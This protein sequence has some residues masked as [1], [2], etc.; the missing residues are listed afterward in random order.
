M[1]TLTSANFCI[2]FSRY[3]N[4]LVLAANTAQSFTV[5]AGCSRVH[6][7]MDP[8]GQT[9]WVDDQKT[10][11]IPSSNVVDGSA[12]ECNPEMR[13]VQPGQSL[14]CISAKAGKL[15][16]TCYVNR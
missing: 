9:F 4:V 2:P 13:F 7:N 10:A 6:F 15:S 11:V 8:L 14:S 1:Q 12:P 16:I 3:N 5:P